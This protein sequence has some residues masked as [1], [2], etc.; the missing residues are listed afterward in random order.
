MKE[1]LADHRVLEYADVR[2]ETRLPLTDPRYV[3]PTAHEV[4][5][6]LHLLGFNE[7][8]VHFV[9]VDRPRLRRWIGGDSE[10]PYSAWRVLL[11][12]AGLALNE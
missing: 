12:E 10:I 8:L 7:S 5:E 3:P 9:G 1:G 6:V 2:R 4:S 11:S